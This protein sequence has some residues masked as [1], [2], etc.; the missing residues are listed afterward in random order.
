ML[1]EE[2]VEKI[3]LSMITK[4]TFYDIYARL[5]LFDK[6]LRLDGIRSNELYRLAARGAEPAT[7]PALFEKITTSWLTLPR[8]YRTLTADDAL[9]LPIYLRCLDNESDPFF[10]NTLTR[11]VIEYIGNF[12]LKYCRAS[13]SREK[14]AAALF[15]GF[16][17]MFW[18]N[19]RKPPAGRQEENICNHFFRWA[20]RLSRNT[21]RPCASMDQTAAR[22]S[23]VLRLVFPQADAFDRIPVC[24]W[25]QPQIS[26]LALRQ[27]RSGSAAVLRCLGPSASLY[28][29]ATACHIAYTQVPACLQALLRTLRKHWKTESSATHSNIRKRA[30]AADR[31]VAPVLRFIAPRTK[32]MIQPFIA[33]LA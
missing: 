10:R 13:L 22:M 30:C 20:H 27:G 31:P 33:S 23:S 17:A 2:L 24:G 15:F 1:F 6:A 32:E 3:D 8:A 25:Y 19:L 9:C 21:P 12:T 16:T 14:T 5:R 28:K 4:A 29:N 11:V 7:L 26:L 18:K